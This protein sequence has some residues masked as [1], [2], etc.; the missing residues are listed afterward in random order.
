MKTVAQHVLYVVVFAKSI[1]ESR[2]SVQNHLQP[3]EF[4]D[5]SS[6][7]KSIAV[8][9]SRNDEAVDHCLCYLSGKSFH[10]ALYPT[11]LKETAADELVDVCKNWTNFPLTPSITPIHT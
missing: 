5:C 11:E 7:E 6:G 1:Y 10:A 9:D 4:I 2:S 3:I 8:V